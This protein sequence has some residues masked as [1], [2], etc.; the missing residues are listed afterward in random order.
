MKS[1][2]VTPTLPGTIG[3]CAPSP[4][5]PSAPASDCALVSVAAPLSD[6]APASIPA[7]APPVPLNGVP[8]EP[9]CPLPAP[10]VPPELLVVPNR[11]PH[12]ASARLTKVNRG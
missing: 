6:D 8:P 7:V 4:L 2:A 3:P 11:P 1:A 5:V 12:P 10:P 9:P